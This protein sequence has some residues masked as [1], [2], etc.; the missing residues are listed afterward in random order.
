MS[1]SVVDG[2]TSQGDTIKD[3]RGSGVR[4]L[5]GGNRLELILT[6]NIYTQNTQNTHIKI[7]CPKIPSGVT[8]GDLKG[9]DRPEIA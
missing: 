4:G 3:T 8:L 7:P 9:S 1:K 2:K 5:N 6:I